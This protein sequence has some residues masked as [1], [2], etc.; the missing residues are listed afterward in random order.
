ME[1]EYLQPKGIVYFGTWV[2]EKAPVDTG[3]YI[4]LTSQTTILQEQGL[5]CIFNK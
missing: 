2:D 3:F 1:W 4:P 5:V